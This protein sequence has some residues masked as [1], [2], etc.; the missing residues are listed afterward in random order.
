M[1]YVLVM[2]YFNHMND[3]QFIG[4]FKT[5]QACINAKIEVNHE[6]PP[7]AMACVEFTKADL[8]RLKRIK[9]EHK[10]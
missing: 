4:N 2:F 10:Y 6:F 5:H 7:D 3:T 8:A 1:T 9:H